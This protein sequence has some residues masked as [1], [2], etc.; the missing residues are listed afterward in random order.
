MTSRPIVSKRTELFRAEARQARMHQIYGSASISTGPSSTLIAWACIGIAICIIAFI[1]FARFPRTAELYGYVAPTNGTIELATPIAGVLKE[2]RVRPGQKVQA[3]QILFIVSTQR[4]TYDG[5]AAELIR[6]GIADRKAILSQQYKL[7][8]EQEAR[9]LSSIRQDL[10]AVSKQLALIK[11]EIG[12]AEKRYQLLEKVALSQ[13]AVFRQGYITSIQFQ[14]SEDDRLSAQ[15]R[16]TSLR[17]SE[18]DLTSTLRQKEKD[19]AVSTI[20]AKSD[21]ASISRD[22]RQLDQ[23]FVQ[24]LMADTQV[25]RAPC[26]GEITEIHRTVGNTLTISQSVG[27]MLPSNSE[28]NENEI[29]IYSTSKTVGFIKE[30][31][32]VGIKYAAYPYQKFGMASGQVRVV[33]ITPINAQDLPPGQAQNLLD[34]FGTKEPLFKITVKP[35]KQTIN[36]YGENVQPKSGMQVSAHV[37][38]ETRRIYEW[39]LDPLRQAFRNNIT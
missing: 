6:T 20:R 31:L 28:P 29:F 12:I 1:A 36:V 21:L 8:E 3:N 16:L 19:L 34:V 39:I 25:M 9:E 2:V 38:L 10:G 24:N 18:T 5:N 30:G 35:N 15:G 13:E 4:S 17:R 23:E 37:I 14:Q 22:T 27:T 7:R 32:L 33:G 11:E 26:D